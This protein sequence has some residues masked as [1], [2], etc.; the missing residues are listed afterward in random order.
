[1]VGILIIT[2]SILNQHRSSSILLTNIGSLVSK[3]TI[4]YERCFLNPTASLSLFMLLESALLYQKGVL[5]G[6]FSVGEER[7]MLVKEEDNLI[8]ELTAM[9]ETDSI[10]GY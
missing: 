5:A 10:L 4:L 6:P 7:D 8:F 3:M 2:K 1:M 9:L